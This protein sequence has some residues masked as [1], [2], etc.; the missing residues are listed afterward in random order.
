MDRDRFEELKRK[1]AGEGLTDEEAGEL[2][3]MYAE[4]R[5][6]PYQDAGS[7]RDAD[8]A[9]EDQSSQ[10]RREQDAAARAEDTE[11]R[12]RAQAIPPGEAR[13]PDYDDS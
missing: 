9:S 8:A 3:R 13:E 5:G 2:G 7:F 11:E 1:A 6:E 4:E 12:D 10:Q